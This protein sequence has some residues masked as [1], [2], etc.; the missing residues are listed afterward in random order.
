MPAPNLFYQEKIALYTKQLAA[1]QDKMRLT[2]WLRLLLFLGFAAG[3]YFISTKF[4]YASLFLSLL[5]LT[6][7]LTL[8]RLSS[9]LAF[10][11]SLHKQLLFVNTN[12][13]EI[14]QGGQNRFDHGERYASGQRYLDDLDIFG[15]NSLYHLLNRTTTSHGSLRLAGLLG[16]PLLNKESIE[17]YQLAVKT[18]AGQVEKRQLLTASG[19]VTGEKEG[20]LD[21]VSDWLLAPG[22]LLRKRWLMALLWLLPASS[23]FFLFVYL[24][25]NN[26]LP[27][28]LSVAV[29]WILIGFFGKYIT[30]Q[31]VLI[32]RKQQVLD[33]YTAILHAFSKMDAG[34]STRL[35][36]L[37][38]ISSDAG[39]AIQKLSRLTQLFDQRLNMLV[40]LLLNSL[41]LYDIQCMISLEKWKEQN[42]AH[43]AGWIQCVGDLECINSLAGFAYNN[44]DY[45]YPQ[46]EQGTSMIEAIQTAHPLIP[47]KERVANDF[48]I[49]KTDK[50]H[51]ITGSNMSGKTTFL[52]TIGV[53]LLLAQ[54]GACVCA[55]SFRFVPM[56]ILSSI[57]ISD[58]LQEHTSYFMAELKRLHQIVL[59]LQK[60]K[61]AL[62]LI[63][64]ILR[65]TNSED[66]T[67]G[68][69]QFIRKLLQYD[70]LVLFATHD[71]TLS[72]LEQA[73][74]GTIA[75][76]CFES[77][78][79][80]DELFFD[81]KLQTG[82]AKNK[83]ASFLMKKM[84]II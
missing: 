5:T 70:C 12:E 37:K 20:S 21:S 74:P 45:A 47:E 53:N 62:V 26:Y 80:Q 41:F 59:E 17:E 10:Q 35:Q 68:S 43:F 42:K 61:P 82:V 1:I 32:S 49:G 83:N 22:K 75:N 66:K 77:S 54:I 6:G 50:L 30:V 69:E 13:W 7:F 63:D 38:H 15:L 56:S 84:Q 57:R 19:L 25:T 40:T 76:H 58:S 14:L 78:I 2:A 46:V 34:S 4:T 8:V 52:R 33:Q 36:Q 79:R 65:G 11:A 71:L 73:F 24:A 9:R 29:N 48:S 23:I 67:H 44:P 31:H 81:Y 16:E 39:M 55:A 18:L 60:G 51:L 64:E 27:L 28:V 3:I 72:K